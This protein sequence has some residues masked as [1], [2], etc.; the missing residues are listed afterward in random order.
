MVQSWE[1]EANVMLRS[2]A[3][4]PDTFF[5]LSKHSVAGVFHQAQKGKRILFIFATEDSSPLNVPQS[6]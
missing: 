2:D 3:Q 6:V 5:S 1:L 4:C